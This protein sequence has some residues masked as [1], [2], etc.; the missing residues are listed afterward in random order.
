MKE[1]GTGWVFVLI[2]NNVTQRTLFG[3]I[4][5]CEL[6]VGYP[7]LSIDSS[8]GLLINHVKDM[9]P[10]EQRS[11]TATIILRFPNFPQLSLTGNLI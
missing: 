5:A 1:V 6:E 4:T 2:K 8:R 9:C 11:F 3:N 10:V 7:P